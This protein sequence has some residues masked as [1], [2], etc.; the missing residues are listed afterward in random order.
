MSKRDDGWAVTKPGAERASA[1]L[2]TQAEAA[3]RAKEILAND[4]GGELRIRGTNGQVREQNT[5]PPGSDPKKS[6]G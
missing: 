1:V 3:A 5:V 4:G 2:P 6:K